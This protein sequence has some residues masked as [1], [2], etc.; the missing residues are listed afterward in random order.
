MF[1]LVHTQ[2]F[3]WIRENNPAA[4]ENIAGKI[5]SMSGGPKKHK[6]FSVVFLQREHLAAARESPF[7][8]FFYDNCALE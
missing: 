8:D 5:Y 3:F 4:K 7:L 6:I 1:N 2:L